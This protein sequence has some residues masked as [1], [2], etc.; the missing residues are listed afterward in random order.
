MIQRLKFA[1]DEQ[2]NGR[3]GGVGNVGMTGTMRWGGLLYANFNGYV[4]V[5]D[6]APLGML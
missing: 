1:L 2:S 3:V 6:N 5:T 4:F